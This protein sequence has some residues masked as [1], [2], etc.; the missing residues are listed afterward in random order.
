[1]ESSADRTRST[2]AFT[3]DFDFTVQAGADARL[4]SG[5]Q[6]C[7]TDCASAQQISEDLRTNSAP[8]SRRWA[9]FKTRQK[10]TD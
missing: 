3:D 4:D 1:M 5:D 8:A 2:T 9:I 10:I 7:Y 6:S